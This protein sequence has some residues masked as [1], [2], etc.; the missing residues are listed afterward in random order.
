MIALAS[1]TV[2]MTGKH[3]AKCQEGEGGGAHDLTVQASAQD[4]RGPRSASTGK[5]KALPRVIG[6]SW[7]LQALAATEKPS[8]IDHLDIREISSWI[9][10]GKLSTFTKQVFTFWII[11]EMLRLLLQ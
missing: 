9:I 11:E 5:F 2:I 7:S 3:P 6:T 4:K 10:S 1:S 8:L